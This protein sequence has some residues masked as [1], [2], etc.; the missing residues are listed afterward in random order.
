MSRLLAYC[1]APDPAQGGFGP[2]TVEAWP[3]AGGGLLVG[4]VEPA[5]AGAVPVRRAVKT[6]F[7]RIDDSDVIR[8]TLPY[9]TFENEA[10]A[11]IRVA[12]ATELFV[13][14]SRIEIHTPEYV[15]AK[16]AGVVIDIDPDAERN[17]RV[18]AA[19]ARTLLVSA[20]AERLGL[21]AEMHQVSDGAVFAS[22]VCVPYRDICADAA[23]CDAPSSVRLRCGRSVTLSGATTD[24][25]VP[26]DI[27]VLPM[28]ADRDQIAR[29]ASSN[30]KGEE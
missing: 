23:L 25:C 21:A 15:S 2:E 20:A 22:E 28:Q 5:F 17:L 16:P 3:A 14:E 9:A 12:V 24:A 8:V 18:C 6:I 26:A 7:I 13:H 27:N 29:L 19:V 30:R 1:V 4:I 11:C 10:H